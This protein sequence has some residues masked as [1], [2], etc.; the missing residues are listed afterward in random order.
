M[1]FHKTLAGAILAAAFLAMPTASHAQ[2]CN[3]GQTGL[4]NIGTGYLGSSSSPN[5][6]GSVTGGPV[7][8]QLTVTGSSGTVFQ[9][10]YSF[11]PNW[12]FL[13]DHWL[14]VENYLS[15]TSQCDLYDLSLPG[16]PSVKS[17]S[18]ATGNVQLFGISPR[19]R[20]IFYGAMGQWHIL[21]ADN[22]LEIY[23]FS[24]QTSPVLWPLWAPGY[25]AFHYALPSGALQELH[26]HNMLYPG[27]VLVE[28][29]PAL[30]KVEYSPCG[31]AIGVF[32]G[33]TITNPGTDAE[34]HS[35]YTGG[36]IGSVTVPANY[37]T[38]TVLA[39]GTEHYA[40]YSDAGG[41]HDVHLADNTGTAACPAGP[42]MTSAV[43]SPSHGVG[44][45]PFT[46]TGTIS[47]PAGFDGQS[48]TI[49]ATGPVGG[50]GSLGISWGMTSGSQFQT[51][52][53]VFGSPDTVTITLSCNHTSAQTKYIIDP[54]PP[55]LYDLY[56]TPGAVDAGTQTTIEA[57]LDLAALSGGATVATSSSDPT[58]LPVPSSIPIAQGQTYNGVLVNTP[59]LVADKSVTVTGSY[60]GVVKQ[61]TLTILGPRPYFLGALDNCLVGGQVIHAALRISAAQ[62]PGGF[63][64]PV[65]SSD[66][67]HAPSPA[68]VHFATGVTLHTL[69]IVT[70]L[71]GSPTSVTYTAAYNGVSQQFSVTLQPPQS[72]FTDLIPPLNP[73]DSYYWNRGNAINNN[74]QVVGAAASLVGPGYAS[75]LWSSGPEVELPKLDS[76]LQSNSEAWAVNDAGVVVGSEDNW[77][78]R[79]NGTTIVNLDPTDGGSALAVNAAGKVAGYANSV[80]GTQAFMHDGTLHLLGTLGGSSSQA[81]GMNASDVVVGWANTADGHRHAFRWTQLGGMEDLGLPSGATDAVAT[82][83]NAGGTVAG[84]A[85]VGGLQRACKWSGGTSSLLDAAGVSGQATAVNDQNQIVGTSS[86]HPVLWDGAARTLLDA[87]PGVCGWDQY[88][89]PTGINNRGQIVGTRDDGDSN[90]FAWL[91]NLGA[92]AVTAVMPS[93]PQEEAPTTLAISIFGANPARGGVSLRCALPEMATATLELLDVN[94][95]RV[96]SRTLSEGGMVQFVEMDE[97]H[98]IAPGMYFARLTQGAH[99]RVAR[100]VL[101]H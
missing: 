76:S 32:N 90:A 57:G 71:V 48:V 59:A 56:F 49:S 80:S 30:L 94:G 60:S 64:L 35:T 43:A 84:Y 40:E 54:T 8:Y 92:P 31:D 46:I 15:G 6:S 44:G 29:F 65:T 34:L 66:P 96:A 19:S 95:R 11:S 85:V 1:R 78:F 93:V 45:Q 13:G 69:D 25:R 88:V 38:I 101:V 4:W 3:C 70:L 26:V 68:P 20:F 33:S 99:S 58:T 63:D 23:S 77:P 27:D 100:V 5:Y 55:K 82:A 98:S 36:V 42:V 50:A 83:I 18:A 39:D 75:Y 91:L 52:S 87:M 17:F 79:W 7:S 62:T 74:G 12:R 22:L 61:T 97:T 53:Q 73:T 86:G 81:T 41:I 37:S 14:A 2:S 21:R 16:A 89:N 72:F 9:Q 67:A 47:Q 24:W 28:G 51:T 10:S